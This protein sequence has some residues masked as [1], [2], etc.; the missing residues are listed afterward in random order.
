MVETQG[1][2][3]GTTPFYEVISTKGLRMLVHGII[4]WMTGPKIQ[5]INERI[6]NL[7]CVYLQLD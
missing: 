4:K 1:H 7:V 2:P 6:F 5:E 3:V